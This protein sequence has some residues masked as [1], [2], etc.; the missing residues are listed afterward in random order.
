MQKVHIIIKFKNKAIKNKI[1]IEKDIIDLYKN[2]IG[3]INKNIELI[4]DKKEDNNSINLFLKRERNESIFPIQKINYFIDSNEI[5]LFGENFVKNN[6]KK[7]SIIINNK[8][9]KLI[10]NYKIKK[11]KKFLK[12]KLKYR[13]IIFSLCEMFFKCSSLIYINDNLKLKT[14]YI[15][16]IN[17]MFYECTC[18][19]KLPDFSKWRMENIK[20]MTELFFN[21]INLKILPD[22]SK[23]NTSNIINMSFI[24]SECSSLTFFPDISKWDISNANDVPGLFDGCSSL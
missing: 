9:K 19:S 23:W 6:N 10:S 8:E 12:I 13:D 17:K 1:K 21:C 3:Q 7:C 5:T 11:E 2:S 18:L 16:D 4:I 14:K 24:F 22:I 15:N 20:G